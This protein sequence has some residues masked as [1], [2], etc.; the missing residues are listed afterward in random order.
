MNL[1]KD[2]NECETRSYNAQ[3]VCTAHIYMLTHSV[4]PSRLHQHYK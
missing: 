3:K 2:R 1:N 4:L